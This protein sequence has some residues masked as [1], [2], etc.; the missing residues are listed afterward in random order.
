[1]TDYAHRSLEIRRRRFLQGA[2]A[3]AA[4]AAAPASLLFPSAAAASPSYDPLQRFIQLVP[5]GNGIIYAIQADGKLLWYRHAAW[6]TGARVWA[7]GGA[8]RVIGSGWHVFRTVLGSANGQLFGFLP[9]GTIHWY[10]YVVSN[11]NTGAGGWASGGRGPVVGSGFG[12][13]PRVLGGW[14]GVI[15]G[16]DDAGNLWWYKYVAGNGTSGSGAW[17]NGGRG[18]RIGAGFKVAERAWAEPNGVLYGVAAAGV[19]YWWRYLGSNGSV[20]WANRGAAV[21]I[22]GGWGSQKQAFANGSGTIYAVMLDSD[23]LNGTDDKLDWYRLTNS[24]SIT[25]SSGAQWVNGGA[26]ALVGRGFTVEPTATLQGYADKLSVQPTDTARIAVSTTFGSYT[27]TIVRLAPSAADPV[28]VTSPG[29]VAGRLQILPAGYRANGCGWATSISL[30]I[31]ASWRSGIYAAK[32]VAPSGLRYYVVFVVRPVKPSAPFA[33][34]MPTN[35]YNAYNNWAGHNR[36]TR[37]DGSPLTLTLLRP[38]LTTVVDPPAAISHTLHNDLFLLR[39]MSGRNINFDC[40]DDGDLDGTASWLAQYKALVVAGHS[41]YW[42]DSMRANLV[43]YLN[44]GGRLICTGGNT[45]YE[46]TAFTPDGN[47]LVYAPISSRDLFRNHNEWESQIIGGNY[48]SAAYFTFSS[49]QVDDASHPLLAGT[50]L[51]NGDRFG[52]VGYDGAASGWEVNGPIDTAHVQ[53]SA[54]LLAHGANQANNGAAMV[55]IDK[56]NGGWVFSANSISFN[57]ALPY[58]QKMAT[59]L[60][61]VFKSAAA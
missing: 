32:L 27:A 41:E 36:Y 6:Q 35:T 33:F 60:Q 2:A 5:G 14:D 4:A 13:F 20:S 50:G 22:A 18:S 1:M 39:W 28:P 56:G 47:A 9:D 61:N 16:I 55:Y 7:N 25:P 29:T 46:R 31:P 54:T 48:N 57:G 37:Q 30:Q 53:G 8:A 21:A 24:Q 12:K 15:F 19:L 10:R 45:L 38:T 58:D 40:Y 52:A 3:T 11:L 43:T 51:A 59:I 42:T 44:S 26:G 23:Q 17:A 49:Y 34:V